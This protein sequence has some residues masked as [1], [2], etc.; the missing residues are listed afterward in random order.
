MTTALIL[1]TCS[2]DLTSHN[3][4]IWPTIGPVKCDDW[5][6]KLKCGN[7]LHGLLWGVGNGSL[8]N[9]SPDAKWLIVRVATSDIVTINDKVKFP[10]GE[11]VHCGA[12]KSATDFLIANGAPNPNDIVGAFITV[13]DKMSATAGYYGT[14]T[15]GDSGTATAGEKG[16]ATAGEKGTA[17]AGDYGTATAGY[18]GTATAGDYGTATAGNGGTATA[19]YYG[20]A[21]AG[22][23]G[24]I[25]IKWWDTKKNRCYTAIGY[26]GEDGIEPNVAYRVK[27]GQLA[28]VA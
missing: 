22:D 26:V 18:G 8:L 19:G 21:T 1:R 6:S 14:A 2:A 28:R 10:H 24:T 11:V 13:G 27:N 7:G 20:T 5:D 4:F 25:M 3:G 12:R 16:T 15:A 23:S 9:W 17:T